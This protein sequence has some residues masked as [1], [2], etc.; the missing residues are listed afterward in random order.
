[1][2]VVVYL[3]FFNIT[4]SPNSLRSDCKKFAPN[5]FNKT[6]CSNCFKQKEEHS[7]EALECNRVSEFDWPY[8]TVIHIPLPAAVYTVSTDYRTFSRFLSVS[9][10]Y[11]SN[12]NKQCICFYLKHMSYCNRDFIAR[13]LFINVIIFFLLKL[14]WF[15]KYL[16]INL[17]TSLKRFY[18]LVVLNLK[19]LL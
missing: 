14:I 16:K 6:K 11:W 18:F 1:M 5:I 17:L 12:F 2:C 15:W 8:S 7:Q 3:I 9:T 19:M 10:V 4:M 13:S